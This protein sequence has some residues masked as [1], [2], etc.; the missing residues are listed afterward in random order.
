MR[1]RWKSN[2]S[3]WDKPRHRSF[4]FFFEFRREFENKFLKHFRILSA[5][6][7]MW[8]VHKNLEA[9]NPGAAAPLHMLENWLCK[10]GPK[11]RSFGFGFCSGAPTEYKKRY[12][13]QLHI[14]LFFIYFEARR[15]NKLAIEVVPFS[16]S[17]PMWAACLVH[18]STNWQC[19]CAW[20]SGAVHSVFLIDVYLDLESP[21]GS[22]FWVGESRMVTE[23]NKEGVSLRASGSRGGRVLTQEEGSK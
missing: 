4:M 23:G 7:Y 16:N 3:G 14:L 18:S 19:T 10:T 1:H 12:S 6:T 17:V 2:S 15:R 22:G 9:K 21:G 8:P 13:T 11:N 5:S 20:S